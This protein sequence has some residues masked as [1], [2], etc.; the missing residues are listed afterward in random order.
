V[1][2]VPDEDPRV[3]K[4][5]ILAS[6]VFIVFFFLLLLWFHEDDDSEEVGQGF[7]EHQPVSPTTAACGPCLS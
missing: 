4:P 1:T 3:A 2:P 7:F 6:I 5:G